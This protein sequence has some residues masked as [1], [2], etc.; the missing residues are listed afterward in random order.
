MIVGAGA[1]GFTTA[2]KF[3]KTTNKK[4]IIPE[5]K[6]KIDG[7]PAIQGNGIYLTLVKLFKFIFILFLDYKLQFPAIKKFIQQE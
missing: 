7:I 4:P 1:A 6:I 3:L 2:Y 5:A